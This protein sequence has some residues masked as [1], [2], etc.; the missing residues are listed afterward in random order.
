[1]VVNSNYLF[2]KL[3]SV[4]IYLD[5]S[6]CLEVNYAQSFHCLPSGKI[7]IRCIIL[8]WTG[9]YVAQCEVG[10]FVKCGVLPCRRDKL[11]GVAIVKCYKLFKN[12]KKCH[13]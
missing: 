10:K 3:L 4:S 12:F 6:K 2:Y 1:M 11:K 7:K 5:I 8:L 13:L 9:D